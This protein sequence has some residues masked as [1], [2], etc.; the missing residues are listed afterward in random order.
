MLLKYGLDQKGGKFQLSVC[1]IHK[2]QFSDKKNI[3]LEA[4]RVEAAKNPK[5]VLPQVTVTP[6]ENKKLEKCERYV[7]QLLIRGEHIALVVLY[8]ENAQKSK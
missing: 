5:I 1:N 6:C 8:D 2:N 7:K 3:I 4:L